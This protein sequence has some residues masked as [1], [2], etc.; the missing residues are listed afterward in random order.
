MSAGFSLV[1]WRPEGGGGGGKR[2]KRCTILPRV[3]RCG[4]SWVILSTCFFAI[5][6][7]ILSGVAANDPDA[8]ID[9][10]LTSIFGT[11]YT[12]IGI[13]LAAVASF[14]L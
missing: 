12:G 11:I 2:R 9:L 7:A 4:K 14:P 1:R 8:C 5:A 3:F 10:R 13:I 6:G